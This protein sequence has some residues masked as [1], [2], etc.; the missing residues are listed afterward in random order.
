MTICVASLLGGDLGR[1]HGH[2]LFL[3]ISLTCKLRGE[4]QKQE[5]KLDSSSQEDCC[6][7]YHGGVSCNPC[8]GRIPPH[9]KTI[10]YTF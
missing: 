7:R 9:S 5:L 2:R 10:A 3:P 6:N 4:M 8:S 1:G